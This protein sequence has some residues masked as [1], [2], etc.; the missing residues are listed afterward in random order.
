MTECQRAGQTGIPPEELLRYL[1]E[2]AEA[3]RQTIVLVTHEPRAAVIADRILFLADGLISN[4]LTGASQNQVLEV[5]SGL[6]S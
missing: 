3:Y 5:M 4:E 1:R 6:G 2:S